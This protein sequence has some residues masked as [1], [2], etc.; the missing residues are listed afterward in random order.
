MKVV[1]L[2]GFFLL[3]FRVAE[4]AADG[5][6]HPFGVRQVGVVFAFDFEVLERGGVGAHR[7]DLIAKKKETPPPKMDEI[8]ETSDDR[9]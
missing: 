4:E 9:R 1:G 6:G 8:N 5:P 7:L 3:G 2:T